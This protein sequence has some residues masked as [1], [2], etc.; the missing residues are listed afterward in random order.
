[1]PSPDAALRRFLEESS[2][3]G[4]FHGAVW[5]VAEGDRVLSTGALGDAVPRITPTTTET[6]FD[7]ASL[8]KPLVT[9]L[10]IAKFIEEEKLSLDEPIAAR[11]PVFQNT[12]YATVTLKHIVSHSAGFPAWKPFYALATAPDAALDVI[13]RVAPAY[14]AG[15][16]VVY[17]DLG[18]IL[19]GKLLETLTA[20]RLD[21][22]F[23]KEIS[24]PLGLR[25][26]G[27][28]PSVEL[29]PRIAATELG[30]VHE[31]TMIATM[32]FPSEEKEKVAAYDG[33]RTT[34]VH[35]EVHDG[36][37]H[38]FEG[39]SGHAG[40]FAPVVEV[41]T[42]AR[43]FL[44]GSRL[45][46][47]PTLDLFTTSL[48]P[49]LDEERS[50]GWMLASTK[51]STAG[52][53]LSPQSFGHLGFT[54]TSLWIDPASDRVYILLTNRTYPIRPGLNAVRRTFNTLGA[55]LPAER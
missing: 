19:L 32:D 22:L 44:P 34:L 14:E 12:P 49:G 37:A 31:R 7:L 20:T 13:A 39:I 25:A 15:T 47:R 46:N 35:G 48:T 29:L 4:E 38:F 6:V 36:N 55:S 16:R 42:I 28:R 24:V 50:V 53:K 41:F 51:N 33:W 30:N 18:Y 3:N 54:G 45:F 10:L 21:L 52:E 11:L 8:T 40:L 5:L 26:T 27:F 43:Q 17:S 1:M 2:S 9:G 23:Q